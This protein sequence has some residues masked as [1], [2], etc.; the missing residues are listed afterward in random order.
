M[1]EDEKKNG[2]TRRDFLKTV[3]LAGVASTGLE[4]TKVLAAQEQSDTKTAT[5][6]KRK[7]GKTGVEVSALALGGMFD[8]VNNQL[9]LRQARNWGVTYWD[10]AEGY[11]NG[12]SEEGFGR[13]FARN[14]EARKEIFLV[15][16]SHAGQP[17][18]MTESLDTS[19]KKLA[20]DYVDMFFAHGVKDFAELTDPIREWASQMKKAGK[21]KFFGFS[22]H[23]NMEDCLLAAAKTDWIDGIMFTYNFRLMQTQKMKD[24]ISACVDKDI[25]LV[26]MKTQGGGPIKTDSDAEL[27]MAGRFLERGFTDKQAK[28]KA[29]LENPN[30]ASI[31]SQMP[32]LTIL[33]ANV[34]ATRDLTSL[35]GTEFDLLN[36]FAEETQ[37]GYCAGCGRICS[38]A[39]GGGVPISDVMRCLM[40]YRDY[41]ERDLA[42][43]VF[44]DLSEKARAQLTKID[45]SLAEKKCPQGLA[46][47]RL[48]HEAATLLA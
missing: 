38:E 24:A 33:S 25:G 5:M 12:L 29:V 14:P 41:G 20:T 13:F 1:A 11:G 19:L 22:T 17:A 35:A 3:G 42:R 8:T 6:P 15:T 2:F 34:A 30:I 26:A 7:L 47:A 32:N 18:K 37:N 31:C 45:Y 28:I 16:K 39:C 23:T 21:I 10:T 4:A 9:L 36:R 43:Q 44:A 48:M 27:Q 46:I 40:Y